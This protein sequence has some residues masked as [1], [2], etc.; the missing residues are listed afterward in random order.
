MSSAEHFS[1]SPPPL[2]LLT[3]AADAPEIQ[4]AFLS[5]EPLVELTG[6][7]DM[8]FEFSERQ[9]Y[10]GQ[11]GTNP[12][13]RLISV[14]RSIVDGA[15]IFAPE[16]AQELPSHHTLTELAD[17]NMA[18]FKG[19]RSRQGTRLPT[20]DFAKLEDIYRDRWFDLTQ[21]NHPLIQA[22]EELRIDNDGRKALNNRL[23]LAQQQAT[24]TTI[25]LKLLAEGLV[26]GFDSAEVRRRAENTLHQSSGRSKKTDQ[27]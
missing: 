23:P 17:K 1:S 16:Q 19:I 25:D 7:P 12:H 26:L 13:A 18:F 5:I 14:F 9:I 3:D 11:L 27:S 2:E 4:G 21:A 8:T 6:W 15:Q 22:W 10:G 24:M 20:A